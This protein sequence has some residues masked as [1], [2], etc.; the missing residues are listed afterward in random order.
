M[1]VIT[2]TTICTSQRGC[3]LRER[4]MRERLSERAREGGEEGGN[5]KGSESGIEGARQNWE[6]GDRDR[7]K[8]G[9]WK[10][11]G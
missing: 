7:G 3:G 9:E 6:K 10:A 1:L 2:P 11:R 5:Q 4:G 8:S